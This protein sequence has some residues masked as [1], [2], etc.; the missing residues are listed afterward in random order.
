[1]LRHQL[2]GHADARTSVD[3]PKPT[4]EIAR[5]GIRMPEHVEDAGCRRY[6]LRVQDLV[7]P[8][9]QLVLLKELLKRAKTRNHPIL[10]P[11]DRSGRL[12]VNE[13]GR[14]DEHILR[15]RPRAPQRRSSMRSITFMTYPRLTTDES[16][17]RPSGA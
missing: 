4:R 17:R 7:Y 2:I 14:H 3:A 9:L 12:L 16:R 5:S 8:H 10:H 11:R 13:A 6:A 1:M 15:Q